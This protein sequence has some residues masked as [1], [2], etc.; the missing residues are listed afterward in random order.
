MKS[1]YS[2]EE[3]TSSLGRATPQSDA[4]PRHILQRS[5]P[6]R[7][8][9][10]VT[11]CGSDEAPPAARD[12]VVWEPDG[13][14][15][16]IRN[17]E[18]LRSL[19]LPE[20]FKACKLESFKRKLYRWGFLQVS[21][22]TGGVKDVFY[23]KNFT[24]HNPRLCRRMTI[25][26]SDK[27]KQHQVEKQKRRRYICGRHT[28][29]IIDNEPKE[30]VARDLVPET[31]AVTS[32]PSLYD[33]ILQANLRMRLQQKNDFASILHTPIRTPV[34]PPVSHPT[35]AALRVALSPW[36]GTNQNSLFTPAQPATNMMMSNILYLQ[37]PHLLKR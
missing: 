25:H 32:A 12:C 18:A 20:F 14:S 36:I 26:Y 35:I 31:R 37:N 11:W 4:G 27:E 7:L 9:E 21:Q 3:P 33:E 17:A 29:K 10:M 23:A 6:E 30:S 1:E 22:K 28:E 34:V 5:F 24:R 8:M 15:F 2:A 13:N 16:S 19:V